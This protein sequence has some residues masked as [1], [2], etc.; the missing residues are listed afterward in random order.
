MP[1]HHRR[2]RSQLRTLFHTTNIIQ[3][4]CLPTAKIYTTSLPTYIIPTVQLMNIIR[5][6]VLPTALPKT[7]IVAAY[8]IH[9]ANSCMP[10]H[11]QRRRWQPA[12]C[13][14]IYSYHEHLV[15]LV[16]TSVALTD[17]LLYRLGTT[18]STLG[19]N[20]GGGAGFVWASS[21]ELVLRTCRN[22]Y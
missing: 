18:S 19:S 2:C 7:P 12:A 9:A 21:Y 11:R 15:R 13:R 14:Y 3:I 22:S 1:A 20:L 5:S 4:L 10:A 17:L 16:E 6:Y 8:I